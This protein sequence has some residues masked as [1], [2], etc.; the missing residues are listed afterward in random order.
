MVIGIKHTC[1]RTAIEDSPLLD[2]GWYE[3]LSHSLQ[4]E[5]SNRETTETGDGILAWLPESK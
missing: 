4:C 5:S 3:I 1:E 2:I